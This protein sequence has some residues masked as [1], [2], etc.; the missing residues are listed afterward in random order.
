MVADSTSRRRRHRAGRAR[1]PHRSV[2][3]T[4][5]SGVSNSSDASFVMTMMD[6][7][8]SAGTIGGTLDLSYTNS[9]NLVRVMASQFYTPTALTTGLQLQFSSGNISSGQLSLEGWY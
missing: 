9:G 2:R 1:L 5:A 8:Q 3:C 4:L 7:Q 6:I